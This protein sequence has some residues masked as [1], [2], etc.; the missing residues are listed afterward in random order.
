[1]YLTQT[2]LISMLNH[3]SQTAAAQTLRVVFAFIQNSSILCKS[4]F[5]HLP[6]DCSRHEK[7]KEEN[8]NLHTQHYHTT[9]Y[10]PPP[11]ISLG[12]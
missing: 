12:Q 9:L 1:M 10:S 3:P 11:Q 6:L 2:L 5:D 7:K 8:N 4:Q